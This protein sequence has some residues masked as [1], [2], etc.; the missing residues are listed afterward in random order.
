MILTLGRS[1]ST[2]F[3]TMMKNFENININT[4]MFNPNNFQVNTSN[5]KLLILKYGNNYTNFILKNKLQCEALLY[6]A[7][8]CEEEFLVFKCFLNQLSKEQIKYLID[9]NHIYYTI[10]FERR[11]TLDS[12]ISSKK[13]S[14]INKWGN[15]STSHIKIEF[16]IDDYIKSKK[17]HLNVYKFYHKI[18]RNVKN[19]SYIE[20]KDTFNVTNFLDQ[21]KSLIPELSINNISE[22]FCKKK[23]DN[24]NDYKDKIINYEEVK[25]FINI[26]SIKIN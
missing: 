3:I 12:Y 24:S 5:E 11:N 4:E 25:E 21:I 26:E 7:E 13:A 8:N 19:H 10:I 20:Y 16:N 15:V 22:H 9:N 18:L 23:Q 2:N 17:R 6:L 14:K 1:G